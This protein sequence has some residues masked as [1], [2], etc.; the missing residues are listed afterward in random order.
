MAID[1]ELYRKIRHLHLA[2]KLSQRAIAKQLGISRHTVE[3]YYLGEKL[4]DAR[5]TVAR[6]SPLREATEATIVRMLEQ[7]KTLPKKQ[8]FNA[9]HIWLHLLEKEGI[10]IAESTV[11]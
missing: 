5:K 11:R 4:P 3:K 2:Q 8:R 1:V 9:H 10:A 6:A 7:N